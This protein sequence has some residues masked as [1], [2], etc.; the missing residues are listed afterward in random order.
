[1]NSVPHGHEL[2]LPEVLLGV[3]SSYLT[4]FRWWENCL[5]FGHC[6]YLFFTI[7]LI[8]Q[9]QSSLPA[10]YLETQPLPICWKNCKQ[11]TCG[12]GSL[13]PRSA[14]GSCGQVERSQSGTRAAPALLPQRLSSHSGNLDV[15]LLGS[16]RSIIRPWIIL[17][18]QISLKKL[19]LWNSSDF[20][21]ISLRRINR[22]IFIVYELWKYSFPTSVI[23][24]TIL[25]IPFPC[26]P[27]QMPQRSKQRGKIRYDHIN[28]D[29]TS[30]VK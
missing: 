28:Y 3:R 8:A 11:P 2:P 18:V 30:V 21:E 6:Q 27:L 22:A 14:T 20:S 26:Q 23:F 24:I 7:P 17:I 25:M 9:A 1:M 12:G 16:W 29:F 15:T 13:G 5:S 10:L 19:F 4:G